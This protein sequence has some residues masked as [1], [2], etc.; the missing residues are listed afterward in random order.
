[1]L[2]AVDWVVTKENSI[3]VAAATFGNNASATIT[4][5]GASRVQ[6]RIQHGCLLVTDDQGRLLVVDVES[7]AVRR[8]CRI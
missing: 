8:N 6:V 7:S 4:L 3:Q 5:A 1:V 2:N